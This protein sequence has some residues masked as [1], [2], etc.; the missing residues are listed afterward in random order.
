MIPAMMPRKL[1]LVALV[2]AL[3]PTAVQARPRPGGQLGGRSFEANKTFGLGLELG[4]LAGLTGKVFVSESGAIDFGVGTLFSDGTRSGIFQVYGD[5][6]FHPVSLASI[7]AFE[8]PLYVGIG[9]R[10]WHFS[11]RFDPGA[12]EF[13]GSVV[14][15][16]VPV[17]IAFD[18][19]NLPLDAF[20]QVVP[21][22]DYYKYSS[23][24]GVIMPISNGFA[25]DIDV[26]IG[27][28]YWFK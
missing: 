6:L 11:E 2:M 28:R 1:L 14:G 9:G 27:A 7:E 21:T 15:V 4:S 20:I 10:F 23:N 19:N 18:F 16:R 22:L 5:Y 25:F 3:F 12:V 13:S 24:N 26:S 8:L 17:G